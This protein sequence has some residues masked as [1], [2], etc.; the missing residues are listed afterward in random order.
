MIE[1][2]SGDEMLTRKIE[3][4]LEMNSKKLMSEVL[5]LRSELTSVKSMLEIVQKQRNEPQQVSRVAQPT[6]EIA[7]PTAPV[8][9][10]S[11]TPHVQPHAPPR[12]AEKPIDRNKVAPSSVSIEK[13]F[14]YGNK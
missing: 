14:Y 3:L 9:H 11:P 7:Q 8:S 4:I 5:Q 1:Q 6:Q 12:V 13:I 10:E 2:M